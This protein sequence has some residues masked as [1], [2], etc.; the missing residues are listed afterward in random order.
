MTQAELLEDDIKVNVD[1][2]EF[3][4][5]KDL[6]EQVSAITIDYVKGFLRK[7]FVIKPSGSS[8]TCG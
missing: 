5:N 8:S 6:A 2:F 7:S 3:A 1:G 4:L